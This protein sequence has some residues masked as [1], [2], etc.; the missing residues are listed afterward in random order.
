MLLLAEFLFEN[1]ALKPCSFLNH[2]VSGL[3]HDSFS[4]PLRPCRRQVV[5]LYN[6][7]WDIIG[8]IRRCEEIVYTYNNNLESLNFR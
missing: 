4:P 6:N 1:K 3:E 5:I 7:H 2:Y 8:I